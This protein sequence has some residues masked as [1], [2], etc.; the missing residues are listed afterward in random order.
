MQASGGPERE[1]RIKVE[2]YHFSPSL[3]VAK[4]GEKLRL[5]LTSQ[6][7]QEHGITVDLPPGAK[8]SHEHVH[9]GETM[10]LEMTVPSVP[11]RYNF[12]CP[13]GD[14]FSRGMTGQIV[15]QP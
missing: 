14:H 1:V 9:K 4:P 10:Q 2:D 12:Y 15:A 7:N 13:V 3:I 6:G 8:S 11:G 5:V